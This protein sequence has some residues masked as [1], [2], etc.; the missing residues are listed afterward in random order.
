M[1][2]EYR[3]PH[4]VLMRKSGSWAHWEADMFGFIERRV[5][6]EHMKLV[7]Q[8]YSAL[9]YVSAFLRPHVAERANINQNK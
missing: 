8:C 2:S 6:K 9:S 4:D 7:A 5:L 3:S 1:I